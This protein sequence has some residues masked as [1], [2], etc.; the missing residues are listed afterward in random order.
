M[1]YSLS[2]IDA[3]CKK[4]TRGAGFSW[5]HAEEAGKAARYLAAVQLP[6]AA[7]LAQYLPEYSKNA[8]HFQAPSLRTDAS[9][10]DVTLCP[11]QTAACLC[12]EAELLGEHPLVLGKVA[13]PLL[14]LPALQMIAANK[15]LL[16]DVSWDGVR[17]VCD[18]TGVMALGQAN[19]D[20]PLASEV[21]VRVLN[22]EEVTGRVKA[23][24]VLGQ[25]ID[26]KYWGTLADLAHKTYVPATEESRKG[27]GPAD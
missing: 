24:G 25:D 3:H 9:V 2:E 22:G 15:G 26:E 7:L 5:G 1:M 21:V 19:L 11:I 4:A 8:L 17:L 13:Y 20:T 10:S 18:Q 14:L 23:A 12:D 16:L 6:G 27:A